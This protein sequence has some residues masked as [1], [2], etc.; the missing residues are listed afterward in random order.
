MSDWRDNECKGRDGDEVGNA[1]I[2]G[3][4]SSEA[5]PFQILQII[6]QTL[7]LHQVI[8]LMIPRLVMDLAPVKD[9]TPMCKQNQERVRA[10][11]V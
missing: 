8:T 2:W 11:R 5:A 10:H 6:S 3:A 4:E 7:T 1:E 9:L